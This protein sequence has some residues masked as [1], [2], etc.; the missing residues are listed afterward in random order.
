M[1]VPHFWLRLSPPSRVADGQSAAVGRSG[2]WTKC[3]AGVPPAGFGGVPPPIAEELPGE[4]P[5]QLA[6]EDACATL[7]TAVGRWADGCGTGREF[8]VVNAIFSGPNQ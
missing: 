6:G 1:S 8:G 2:Q 3:G 5:G 7:S 4:T